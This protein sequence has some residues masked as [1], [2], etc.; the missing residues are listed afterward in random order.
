MLGAGEGLAL[1]SAMLAI[2][3]GT[4][5]AEPAGEH[6]TRVIVTLPM[7]KDVGGVA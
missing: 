7:G 1:H 5:L 4:L 6:G 2:V 3:G